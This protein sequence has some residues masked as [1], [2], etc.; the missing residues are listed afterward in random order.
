MRS[1]TNRVIVIVLW[2][3]PQAHRIHNLGTTTHVD[4]GLRQ[5]LDDGLP[6]EAA[7]LQ[8]GECPLLAAEDEEKMTRSWRPIGA[9]GWVAMDVGRSYDFGRLPLRPEGVSWWHVPLLSH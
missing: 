7:R 8:P 9:A 2:T 4:S 1:A 3:L 6:S 5:R